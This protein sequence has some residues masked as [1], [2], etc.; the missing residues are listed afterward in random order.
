V[1]ASHHASAAIAGLLLTMKTAIR[2]KKQEN[3]GGAA[4][5]LKRVGLA[6]N[7]ACGTMRGTANYP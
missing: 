2:A 7:G 6:R 1:N 4:A 3:T 5:R